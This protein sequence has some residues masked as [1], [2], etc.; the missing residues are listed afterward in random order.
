MVNGVVPEKPEIITEFTKGET[1]EDAKDKLKM[2]EEQIAETLA[3]EQN[4]PS[5]KLWVDVISDNCNPAKGR[6][7]EGVSLTV[8][9]GEIEVEIN[10]DDEAYELQFWEN[11][12]ILYELG[13]NLSMHS[14]KEFYAEGMELCITT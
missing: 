10:A 14:V 7:M 1:I 3:P 13:E 11:A 4:V 8:V 6:S 12:L 5:R 2:E 9:N